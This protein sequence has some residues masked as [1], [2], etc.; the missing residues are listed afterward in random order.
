MK[1][2]VNEHIQLSEFQPSDQVA[3]VEHLRE[4]EIYDRTLRIPYLYTEVD[5]Q[6]WLKIVEK[7]TQEQGRSVHWAIREEDGLLIGG[8][9]FDGFQLGKSH[10]AE[11]GY[12]LA[13]P[14]WCR[15]I[16]TAVVRR[17]CEFAFS[18]AWSGSPPKF[19]PIIRPPQECYK[20]LA[21]SKKV[22]CGSII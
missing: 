12:W 8:C 5:F 6:E 14:F 15:G 20:R 3:C 9:G 21:S 10:R 18:V 7:T 16:M 11:I 17:I 19:S 2:S 4:K 1:I 13:K 22:T